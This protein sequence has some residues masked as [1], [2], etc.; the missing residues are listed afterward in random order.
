MTEEKAPFLSPSHL[1]RRFVL[2]GVFSALAA[3]GVPALR[4]NIAERKQE[5]R[6]PCLPR[7]RDHRRDH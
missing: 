1:T 4:V 2:V 5:A 6:N 3:V 7:G